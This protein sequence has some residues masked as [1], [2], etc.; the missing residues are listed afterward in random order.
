MYVKFYIK[1]ISIY[2]IICSVVKMKVED[3]IKHIRVFRELV[4]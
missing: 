3:R 4:Y 1:K 2:G